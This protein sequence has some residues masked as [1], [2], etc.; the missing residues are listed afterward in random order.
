MKPVKCDICELRCRLD[1]GRTG[2]CGLYEFNGKQSVER[3]PDHYLLDENYSTR[4]VTGFYP[5]RGRSY[6][7]EVSLDY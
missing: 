5:D 6:G 2:I 1:G 3:F 7:M 4:Y